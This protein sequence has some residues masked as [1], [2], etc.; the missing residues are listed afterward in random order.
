MGR[1]VALG[2]LETPF[3]F[4]ISHPAPYGLVLSEK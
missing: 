4:E 1:Y 3:L 2:V